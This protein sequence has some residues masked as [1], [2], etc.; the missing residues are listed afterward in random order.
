MTPGLR[1][2]SPSGELYRVG[3]RP[4]AWAWPDWAYAGP[5]GTFGNRYD[6]P[7]GEYRVLYAAGRR[8]GAFLETLARFRVDVALVA[9][10]EAIEGD[11]R[12]GPFP[13]IAPGLVPDTWTATRCLGVATAPPGPFADVA[14]SDSLAHL[15]VALAARLVHYGLDDLDGGDVRRRTP[16]A[17]TQDVSRHVFATPA[18]ELGHPFAGLRYPS[19]LGDE[20][21]NWAIFEGGPP[22]T[23][24]HRGQ[25]IAAQ[26][27]ALQD[28]LRTLDLR[29]HPAARLT[30]APPALGPGA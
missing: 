20:L 18:D 8:R 14:H 6:D 16:R 26:D 9:E 15:R 28:A 22:V 27:P 12:D 30:L 23:V 5:D 19:R 3:R 7:L 25:A 13:T 2:A 24:V 11:E 17:F 4:D 1:A 29:L 21:V 10:M